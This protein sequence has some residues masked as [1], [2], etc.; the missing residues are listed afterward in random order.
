MHTSEQ[1]RADKLSAEVAG[2]GIDPSKLLGW[3]EL[4]R[5]GIIVD[6]PFGA[7]GAG[8]L[9][10]VAIASYYDTPGKERRTR[11]LYPE[12]YLFHFGGRWGL[13]SPFDFWPERKEVF[14]AAQPGEVL[15]AVN[16]HAI[17]HLAIPERPSR[18]T[19]HHYREPEIA[20]DR[21]K[22]CYVYHPSGMVSDPDVTISS[23]HENIL[24]NYET[25]LRPELYAPELEKRAWANP[26]FSHDTPHGRDMHRIIACT[27]ERWYEVDRGE[28]AFRRAAQRV[29]E[30]KASG[31]IVESF[32]RVETESAL[33]MIG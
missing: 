14:V 12:I 30:A 17:T 22:Q 10:S 20:L 4:D 6:E 9:I 11:N 8:L 15:R 29:S 31:N 13:H 33:S 32:R 19:A 24:S 7:L 28:P 5:F 18:T 26:E 2:V 21:I 23:T 25:T 16:A 3:G 1:I 27:H